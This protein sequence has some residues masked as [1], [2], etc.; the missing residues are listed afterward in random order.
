MPLI[1]NNICMTLV[2]LNPKQRYTHLM[3]ATYLPV[4]RWRHSL[5]YVLLLCM[6][7][8]LLYSAHLS[9]FQITKF[10]TH[11]KGIWSRQPKVPSW[12]RVS[13]SFPMHINMQMYEAHGTKTK[14]YFKH[15][16]ILMLVMWCMISACVIV[17][18]LCLPIMNDSWL[19]SNVKCKKNAQL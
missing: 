4:W 5:N 3:V 13:H 7:S 19:L 9:N 6:F 1:Y 12:K 15:M 10:H 17:N 8:Y 11:K 16:H 2:L 18:I 14:I